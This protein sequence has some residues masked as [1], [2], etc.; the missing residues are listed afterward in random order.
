[1]STAA[2]VSRAE[3]YTCLHRHKAVVNHNLLREAIQ[4]KNKQPG[5]DHKQIALTSPHQ[6]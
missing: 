1:M 5:L 2:I 4:V 3:E 6:L